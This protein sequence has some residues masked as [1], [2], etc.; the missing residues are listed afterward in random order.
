MN[1]TLRKLLLVAG[2][3]V[4]GQAAA[5]VTLY[6]GEGFHGR[7][8]TADRTVWNFDRQGFNDRASSAIVQNGTWEACSDARFEGRCVVLRPGRYPNLASLGL[9][10]NIS[11][12]RPAQA[13]VGSAPPGPPI[14]Q[15]TP[16]RRG[17]PDRYE[18]R[19]D[20]WRFDRWEN[21]WE[22]Y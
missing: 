21:R 20:G 13:T 2:I 16:D 8:F 17:N 4:A 11:S 19:N 5:Q 12:I 10:N 9:G 7:S 14:A 6:E 18:Y 15:Y 22:R 3:L 1:R